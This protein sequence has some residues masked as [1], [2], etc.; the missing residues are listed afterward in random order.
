[1]EAEF[2]KPYF[3]RPYTPDDI[4]FIQ[5]SWGSSYYNNVLNYRFLNPDEFHAHHRPIRESILNKPNVAVI[6]CA[7][8]EDPT[9]ILGYSV[10]ESLPN[11]SAQILHY[12][13]VKTAF[14]TEREAKD[15]AHGERIGSQL[16]RR[17]ITKRPVLYTHAT[18]AAER[19]LKKYKAKGRTE[20]DRFLF[21]PHLT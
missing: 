7:S 9:H 16:V 5:G 11:S 12:I 15:S 10:V 4:P 2:E 3:F 1:M 20:L 17:S 6:I 14:R 19:I 8:K 13:Y 21:C 18:I